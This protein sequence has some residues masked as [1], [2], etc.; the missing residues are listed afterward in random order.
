VQDYEAVIAEDIPEILKD[1][2][3]KATSVGGSTIAGSV[4]V[5]KVK[6]EFKEDVKE[7]QKTIAEESKEEQKTPIEE[8]KEEKKIP[9]EE[10]KKKKGKSTVSSFVPV[11]EKII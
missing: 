8:S 9:T 2:T 10:S 1:P 6:K 7:E 11:K 4:M 5:S 3:A